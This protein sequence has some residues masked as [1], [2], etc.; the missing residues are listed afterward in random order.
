ME[1][2][3]MSI[4]DNVSSALKGIF[5]QTEAAAVPG[6][7]SAAL[8]K[9]NLGDLQGVV[10]KLQQ[11]GLGDQV[12]SWLGNGANLPVTGEQ[13]KSALGGA[14]VQQLAAHFGLPVDAA[15]KLLAEHLPAVVDQASPAGT[16]RPAA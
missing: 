16:L 14:Q 4:F 10:T 15:L 5:G 1:D 2:E 11:G 6:L 12:K 8:A 7:I 3:A 9:T 13:L